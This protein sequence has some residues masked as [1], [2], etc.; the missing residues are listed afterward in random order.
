MNN[1]IYC[2]FVLLLFSK[3]G[4]NNSN[5]LIWEEEFNSFELDTN[6]WNV[7]VGNGCPE[8]CGFGNNELQYYTHKEAN[9]KIENGKLIIQ[10]T[11]DTAFKS[12][13]LTTSHK[14]DFHK[15]YIEISAKLPSCLG[16][17]PAIWMLPSLN[18]PLQWP[19]DGEI[20]VMENVGYNSHQVFGTIHTSS[21]NHMNG[22]QLSDSIALKDPSEVYHTY[23]LNWTDSILEWY[24]DD[25]LY[26]K[27]K[28]KKSDQIEEWP[29]DK[30]FHL[31]INQAVG[32]N[33][34][35]KH[36]VDTLSYPQLF[37]IDYIRLYEKK[38]IKKP[39]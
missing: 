31:I 38:P 9:L 17:W 20:D 26:N 25:S 12:A 5:N 10:A 37:Y 23:A 27:I 24:V 33:W 36:G 35:G 22:T 13:K 14:I 8:L 32:G 28:R 34:G 30:K 3:C 18:R 6:I 21:Y 11:F 19:L 29:F 1:Y 15:G 4:N 39:L 2:V 7:Y 16:T